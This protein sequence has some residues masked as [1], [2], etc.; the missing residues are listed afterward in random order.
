MSMWINCMY[1]PSVNV[2]IPL[3]VH[4]ARRCT[5]STLPINPGTSFLALH[6]ASKLA[7]LNAS[8]PQNNMR[9]GSGGTTVVTLYARH[10]RA[11]ARQRT[12]AGSCQNMASGVAL[13]GDVS[14]RCRARTGKG[15]GK[16]WHALPDRETWRFKIVMGEVTADACQR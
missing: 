10:V 4:F 3:P 14:R 1:L 2:F 16:V 7:M 9:N 11:N 8:E 15:H 6:I 13:Y 5:T 12:E